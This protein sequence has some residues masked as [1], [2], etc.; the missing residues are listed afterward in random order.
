MAVKIIKKH[1]AILGVLA[2][3]FSVGFSGCTQISNLFLSD[4][5][6]LTGTWNSDGSWAD[7]PTDIPTVFVFSTNGTFQSIIDFGGFQTTSEGTWEIDDGTIS[8]EIVDFLPLTKYT[9]KF[10][11]DDKILTLTSLNGNTS[12]ILE[13]Q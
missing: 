7:I 5:G 11:G 9:Y 10:S 2:L 12:F 6:R 4:E 8:L 1:I 3:V 13:K